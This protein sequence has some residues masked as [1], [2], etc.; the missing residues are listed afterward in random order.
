MPLPWR[1]G[2]PPLIVAA[3]TPLRDGGRALDPEAIGPMVDFLESHGADG[4][5]CCGTTGEGILLS[6]EERRAA[7]RAF[8][9]AA[10]G[11]L[12]VHAG[13]QTTAETE[14]LAA[15]AAEAGAD[16]VA[17]I[18]PPYFPLD[19][20]A[21][22]AH[23]AAAAAACAPLPFFI[24]VFTRRSGYP[25]PVE[26]IS[27]VRDRAPNLVGLKVSESPMADVAPYLDLGLPVLVGSEPLIV[28]ALTNGAVGT[29]S[30]LAAAFPDEVRAVLDAPGPDGEAR[31]EALRALMERQPFI[32]SVKHILGRRG[33][34]VRPDVRAPLRPLSAEQATRL[35]TSLAELELSAVG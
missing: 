29:V 16:G 10:R 13:A 4:V 22:T 34:P 7:T 9:A 12:L 27:A 24:Y 21:L 18:P 26:V 23:L 31:L 17:V 33:T 2:H 3:A 14:A 19:P 35:D 20:V 32:A 5:F 6:T 8:R 28:P 25:L 15:D 30:G 1:F 11:P